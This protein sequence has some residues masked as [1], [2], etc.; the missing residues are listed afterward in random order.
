MVK[1]V[2]L[3]LPTRTYRAKA[4]LEAARSL[5]L[6]VVVASEESSTLAHLRPDSELVID[7]DE[8]VLAVREVAERA[9]GIAIDAVVPADDGAVLAAAHIS[10][11]LGLPTSS[12]EAVAATRNK[13]L[14]RQRL[15][16]AGVTQPRWWLWHDG[17]PPPAATFPVV[18]KPL[19]QA[20]SRGVIRADDQVQLVSA[21][22]RSRRAA[23]DRPDGGEAGRRADLLVEEFIPGPEVAVEGVLSGGLLRVLAVYDKPEALDGPFFEE[24]VYTVPS[25]LAAAELDRVERAVQVATWGLGLSQ[26]AVHAELRLGGVEPQVVDLASRTIGGRCSAV[27]RFTS[28]RSLEEIVLLSAL[29]E[30]LGNLDLEPGTRGVMMMPVPGA[31]KLQS[32]TGRD[33]V[34]GRDGIDGVEMAIPPGGAVRPLPEGD[35]YLGF[36]FAH[37]KDT[38]QVTALLRTAY[39]DLG[40]V[41]AS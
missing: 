13:F 17:E 1:Q 28:G 29:G 31:G 2:L 3:I 14:L 34:V 20:A 32:V 6:D 41:I 39:Q 25:E 37:G 7:L 23:S 21:G 9:V 5:R 38:Q 30:D 18:V 22:E 8:P 36:I 10:Q 33:L 26:G 12:P 19:D 27:L 24:T 40:I 35:R 16:H 15:A 11:R 4:F